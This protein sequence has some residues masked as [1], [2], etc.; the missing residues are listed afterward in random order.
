MIAFII[1]NTKITGYYESS[2]VSIANSV[3]GKF[4]KIAV[5]ILA[6]MIVFANLMGA[7]WAVSRMVLSLSRENR[8]PIILRTSKNG[9]P[10]SAIVIVSISILLALSMEWLEILDI[11]KMLSIAGQ[12]F[13]ILYGI[14]GIAFLKLSNNFSEKLLAL[15]AILIV[16]V[17]ILLQSSSILYPVFLSVVAI[18]IWYFT[19]WRSRY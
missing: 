13:L 2:F 12:N 11:N 15:T 8:L 5:S 1:Q 10:F 7:I 17:L 3:F 18:I 16:S 9:S 14:T 4:G 6:A 19:I